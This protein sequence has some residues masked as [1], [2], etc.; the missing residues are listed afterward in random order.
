MI[1]FHTI[2]MGCDPEFFFRGSDDKI[3]GAEKIIPKNGILTMQGKVIIDGVQAEINPKPDTCRERLA[4][5]ITAC[6]NS[7]Q[8][9]MKKGIK[10][11]SSQT[12]TISKEEL[13]SLDKKNRVFGCAPSFNTYDSSAKILADPEKYMYRG[14]GGHIH[15]GYH[16]ETYTTDEKGLIPM[17]RIFFEKEYQERLV[18]LLDIILGNTFVLLDRNP[19]NKERRKNYGRAGEYRTPK[20]GVEYRTLSNY[21]LRSQPLMSLAFGLARQCVC[22]LAEEKENYY[23]EFISRIKPKDIVNAINENDFDLAYENFKKIEPLFLEITPDG[24]K[25]N[26]NGIVG[27]NGIY[28]LDTTNIEAFHYLIATGMDKYLTNDIMKYWTN[29]VEGGFWWFMQD[30]AKPAL[31]Q[32]KQSTEVGMKIKL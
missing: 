26:R 8:G 12:V 13:E 24:I 22:I 16:G 15:L 32:A 6:F 25:K 10:I 7:L 9:S 19:G 2:Y 3:I 28:P 23:K 14:A 5:N 17:K 4:N 20:H 27:N 11:D 1:R 30:K 29:M 21:W 31:A 18:M